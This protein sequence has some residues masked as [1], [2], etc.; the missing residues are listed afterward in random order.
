[1]YEHRRVSLRLDQPATLS[2]CHCQFLVAQYEITAIGQSFDSEIDK[3]A[4]A[5]RLRGAATVVEEE[6]GMV[7][8]MAG[9]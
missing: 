9:Q 2:F 5:Q 4:G 1:M 8:Y 6:T 7:G 3:S